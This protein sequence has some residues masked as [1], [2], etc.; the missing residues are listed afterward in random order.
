MFA[1]DTTPD[2]P[3]DYEDFGLT[4]EE[5]KEKHNGPGGHEHYTLAMWRSE[6]NQPEASIDANAY[7]EWVEDSIR[8]DDE[9]Y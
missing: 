9:I 1:V 4:S 6:T 5:L 7:W 3:Y 2:L 8:K